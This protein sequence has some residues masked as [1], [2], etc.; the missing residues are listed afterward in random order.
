MSVADPPAMRPRCGNVPCHWCDRDDWP[1]RFC[2]GSG[3]W[4]PERPSREPSG[5]IGWIRVDEPCRMCGQTGKEHDP[6]PGS[7]GPAG[8]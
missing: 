6:L 7:D 1:C 8:R 2:E 4:R 5:V 3:R